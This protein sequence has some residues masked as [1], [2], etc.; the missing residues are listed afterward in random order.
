MAHISI[1]KWHNNKMQMG[2]DLKGAK[3]IELLRKQ[4]FPEAEEIVGET[5]WVVREIVEGRKN[6]RKN[7]KPV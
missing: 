7:G 1:S 6:N 2:L 5:N 3:S 4:I